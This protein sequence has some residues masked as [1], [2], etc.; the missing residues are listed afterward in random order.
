MPNG[1]LF[2]IYGENILQ[3]GKTRHNVRY[4][5]KVEPKFK[6]LSEKRQEELF[7]IGFLLKSKKYSQEDLTGISEYQ[8]PVWR[9]L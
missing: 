8:I 2:N 1:E 3:A 7:R 5:F 6:L 4:A 9:E